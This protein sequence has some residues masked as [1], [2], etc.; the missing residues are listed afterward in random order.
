MGV[1]SEEQIQEEVKGFGNNSNMDLENGIVNNSQDPADPR[2]C[3]SFNNCFAE[4]NLFDT[5]IAFMR[6]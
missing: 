4:S 2:K 5:N 6:E 1:S 3:N